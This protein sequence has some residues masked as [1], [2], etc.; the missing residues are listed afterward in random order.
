VGELGGFVAGGVAGAKTFAIAQQRVGAKVTGESVGV[1][2]A[3]LGKE[4]EIPFKQKEFVK[5]EIEVMGKRK[6][7][8]VEFP[9][10]HKGVIRP[11]D[12]AKDVRL[13]KVIGA[14]KGKEI[15]IEKEVFPKV[16]KTIVEER[17]LKP[18]VIET[19]VRTG[20][21]GKPEVSELKAYVKPMEVT[22]KGV[23]LEELKTPLTYREI[24]REGIIKEKGI[25]KG[26]IA[27][28]K[29]EIPPAVAKHYKVEVLKKTV[30]KPIPAKKVSYPTTKLTGIEIV[31]KKPAVS[32]GVTPFEQYRE[33]LYEP[34]VKSFKVKW[35]PVPA[36]K[37]SVPTAVYEPKG[38]ERISGKAVTRYRGGI[39]T[40]PKG[41]KVRIGEIPQTIKIIGKR[42]IEKPK[43][44]APPKLTG[45]EKIRLELLR[46]TRKFPAEW[47]SKPTLIEPK[48]I[49]KGITKTITKP[50]TTKVIKQITKPVTTEKLVKGLVRE[51]EKVIT[52]GTARAVTRGAVMGATIYG[53]T[54]A[55][56]VIP[57]MKP[58]RIPSISVKPREAVIQAPKAR[59]I[60][61]PIAKEMEAGISLAKPIEVSIPV[62]KPISIVT[63]IATPI[64]KPA[65]IAKPVTKPIAKPITKPIAIT[66]PITTP[67]TKPITR[68][69]EAIVTT[70]FP[71]PPPPL[72]P[73]IALPT[74]EELM[75][76]PV[77]KK[78]PAHE[79]QV[80]S[81]GKW[82]KASRELLP[83]NLAFRQ[84]GRIV[85][86]TTSQRFRVKK[87]K[88]RTTIPDI[89]K[90]AVRGIARKFRKAK[91]KKN[92][93]I[94]KR[95][96]A[97]DT[98]GE[99]QGITFKGLQTLKMFPELRT[100]KR[101]KK[102][103]E[104]VRKAVRKGYIIKPQELGFKF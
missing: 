93:W 5:A 37:V 26:L 89:D 42:I 14:P 55:P 40:A 33:L 83:E 87:T 45:L 3:Q 94:E 52:K 22:G 15:L 34:S 29:I 72:L 64:T 43:F 86:W 48:G 28:E 81:K 19:K 84:G 99:L 103:K 8:E 100:P 69:T 74:E 13:R 98:L 46:K 75:M 76:A 50:K 7:V 25:T 44:Y 47:E 66:T 20:I 102:R 59:P 31:P 85:D 79:V 39:Y 67:I 71:P 62:A 51:G 58:A 68:P 49:G 17:P 63:P 1:R 88:K 6:P 80:K 101:T 41:Y 57:A 16:P 53:I 36:K 95:K 56:A 18:A 65:E 30:W 24:G 104:A 11:E 21:K 92:V 38:L 97:I 77:A 82:R 35:K 2:R 60:S 10:K 78:K 9:L 96:H 73:I 54:K 4:P 61:K 23:R 70:F 91:K 12:M 32:V 27:A 90:S